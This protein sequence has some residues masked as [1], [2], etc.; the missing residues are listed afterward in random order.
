MTRLGFRKTDPSPSA[1]LRSMSVA[2]I[3]WATWPSAARPATPAP[4]EDDPGLELGYRFAAVQVGY[5]LGWA[6]IVVV[7]AGLTFDVAARHRLLLVGLTLAAA[8]GN[9]LAM[10]IPWRA[11]LGT[12]RGRTLLDL[13]CAGLVAFVALLVAD[14]G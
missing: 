1:Y 13:W 14:G 4:D 7:L 12:R 6:S 3:G 11:W 8:V 5:W 10:I 9:T 2:R